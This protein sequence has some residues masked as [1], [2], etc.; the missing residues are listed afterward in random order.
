MA[1]GLL[2][3]YFVE[4]LCFRP[5]TG[6]FRLCET[7]ISQPAGGSCLAH[8]ITALRL[9]SRCSVI[10]GLKHALQPR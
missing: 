5:Y 2:L 4:K 10:V 7:R 9:Y 1:D 8:E 3:A 6:N